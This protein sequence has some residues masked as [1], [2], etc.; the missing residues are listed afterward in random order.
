MSTSILTHSPSYL[1]PLAFMQDHGAAPTPGFP[2]P[3]PESPVIGHDVWIGASAAILP[4][5]T[6]GTGAIV[7]ANSVVTRD[8]GPYEIVAGNPARLIRKR[9]SDEVIAGL[10]ESEWWQYRFTD[11]NDLP[12]DDPAAFLPLFQKRKADLEPYRPETARM[13]D[14]PHEAQGAPAPLLKLVAE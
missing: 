9:F 13:A 12:L 7:G 5:V 14:M 1:L 6:I 2:N 4:G 3:Q 8:V 11:F 10:L